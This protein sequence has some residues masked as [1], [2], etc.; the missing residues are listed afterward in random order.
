MLGLI[1]S[2]F[3]SEITIKELNNNQIEINGKWLNDDVN[4]YKLFNG[5]KDKVNALFNKLFSN[6]CIINTF[7]KFELKCIAEALLNNEYGTNGY[8]VKVEQLK[9][10][11]E[12]LEE[13]KRDNLYNINSNVINR[14][15]IKDL[16]KFDVLKHQEQALTDYNYFKQNVNYRGM[17]LH[18]GIGSG[19]TAT[20]L[21]IMEGMNLE[22]IIV[23]CPLPTVDKVWKETIGGTNGCAYKTPQEYLDIRNNINYNN[24]KYIIC[25]YESMSKLSTLIHNFNG[26]RTGVIIDESH[27]LLDKKSNR[28]NQ[29]L[30]IIN[31]LNT[32][33]VL[34][35]SGTPLKNGFQELCII[36]QFLDKSFDKNT[37]DRFLKLYK[38]PNKFFSDTLAK[39]YRRNTSVIKKDGKLGLPT[40]EKIT[41]EIKL[42][43]N[44]TNLYLLS[45]ISN[46]LKEFTINRLKEL[47]NKDFIIKCE[48]DYN[49]LY[50]KAKSLNTRIREHEIKE[51]ERNFKT[52]RN[53]KNIDTRDNV[54]VELIKSV[55]KFEKEQLLPYLYETDKKM[56]R[57]VKTILKY[58]KLKTQGEALAHIVGRARID[59]HRLIA[60][61]IDY[62]SIIDSTEKKTI[63]FSSYIDV[64]DSIYNTC[65]NLKYNPIQ[66]Y[67]E[68]VKSMNSSINTFGNVKEVNPLITT[69]KSLSTGVP[70][71][72]ANVI[73][74][75]DL[76]FRNYI[77]EQAIGRAWRL[78][79]DKPVYVYIP[80]LIT[81]TP[82]INTRNIDIMAYFNNIVE[83]ITG[84]KSLDITIDDF[85]VLDYELIKNIN[86]NENLTIKQEESLFSKW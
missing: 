47:T 28:T 73:I 85:N 83:E 24:Q 7:F 31:R 49:Y 12:L 50:S 64:C 66:V 1:K 84:V 46:R 43:N 3:S 55:N 69:Y 56:F 67:G 75:I 27:N 37:M 57:E 14:N 11:I 42:D 61:K 76:P 86:N 65:S 23:I 79:Q 39:R 15:I 78:G 51:Y 81:D 2:F 53:M 4:L 25:N 62:P 29:A 48:N 60:N 8:G 33:N 18:A 21:F 26:K 72:M 45:T 38:N 82:N 63:V 16:M 13:D 68:Y 40:M 22:T 58:P 30:E 20:S 9:Q 52:L 70:L 36:F 6:S 41:L 34:L 17:L 35:L 44:L 32:D 54:V 80:E 59:C 5:K 74:C 19:K 77:Y 10:L 71:I